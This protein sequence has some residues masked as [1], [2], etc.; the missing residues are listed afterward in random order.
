MSGLWQGPRA[1]ADPL[2]LRLYAVL[3]FA[4]PAHLADGA[5][6]NRGMSRRW[7]SG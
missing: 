1:A 7:V 4:P 6:G 3:T 5:A 2:H